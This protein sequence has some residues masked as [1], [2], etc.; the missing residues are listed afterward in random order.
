MIFLSI[1]VLSR[2]ETYNSGEKETFR[3]IVKSR[4]IS[5]QIRRTLVIVFEISKKH[6]FLMS[7]ISRLKCGRDLEENEIYIHWAIR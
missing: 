5:M 2:I 3:E 7:E 1:T 4:K 6:C